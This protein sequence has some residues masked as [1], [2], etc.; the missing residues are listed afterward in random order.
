MTILFEED[1]F[2]FGKKYKGCTVAAI[3]TEDPEYLRKFHASSNNYAISDEVM[4][5]LDKYLPSRIYQARPSED[6][7]GGR[8]HA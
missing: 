7:R 1:I 6:S 2:P 5:H 4:L 8:P 3:A